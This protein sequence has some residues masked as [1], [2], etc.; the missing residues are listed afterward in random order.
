M[1]SGNPQHV[2]LGDNV[3]G[4]LTCVTDDDY[5]IVTWTKCGINIA[6]MKYECE[7]ANGANPT[8]T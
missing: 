3:A 8:Y 5:K 1:L 6:S 4:T 7:L 2:V